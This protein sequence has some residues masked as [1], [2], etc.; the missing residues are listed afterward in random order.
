MSL[1]STW[2]GLPKQQQIAILVGIP[3]IICGLV[4]WLIWTDLQVLGKDEGLVP[5]FL[6]RS[7]PGSSWSKIDDERTQIAQQDTAILEGPKVQADYAKA[8]KDRKAAE[9]RLPRVA[10]KTEVRQEIE[11]L[12]RAIQGA[13][14]MVKL[15]SFNIN[16]PGSNPGTTRRA[17]ELEDWIY[18][19]ELSCDMNGLISFI[20]VLEK[21]PRFMS[22]RRINLRPGTVGPDRESG[23]LKYVLH[24]VSLDV[25]THVYNPEKSK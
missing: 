3:V 18:K 9:E 23:Q 10:D 6:A 1:A 16:Q 14:G 24:T 22:V 2:T 5:A 7:V 20:D 13:Q 4:G 21:N 11:Q 12:A 15:K 25:V 17:T 19:I 8:Q